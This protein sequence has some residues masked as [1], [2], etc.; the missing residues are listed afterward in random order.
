MRDR[1]YKVVESNGIVRRNESTEF[2]KE[3]GR[4]EINWWL[5]RKETDL[6]DLREK[7]SSPRRNVFE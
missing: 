4:D 7:T 2:G 3:V 5:T 1:T 6:E